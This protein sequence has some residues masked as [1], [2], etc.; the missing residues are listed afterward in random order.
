MDKKKIVLIPG[1]GF[2]DD[3]KKSLLMKQLL[4]RRHLDVEFFN[5]NHYFRMPRVAWKNWPIRQDLR[6]WLAEVIFDF[7]QVTVSIEDIK[8]PKADMYIGH[9][10]GS[11]LALKQ[12]RIPVCV[13]GSPAVLI[14]DVAKMQ[15]TLTRED[16]RS[17]SMI[18]NIVNKND[19]LAYPLNLPNCNDVI[20]KTYLS[21]VA[22]HTKY[23]QH[24]KTV[25]LITSWV[26]THLPAPKKQRVFGA[27]M[28]WLF[29]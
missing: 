15:G 2:H 19:P 12:D 5:W 28:Q 14:G 22:A 26:D 11:I 20:I 4:K 8:I 6:R 1:V 18:L 7:Q 3:G 21:P 24:R 16:M 13:F 27:G 9:S 25:N 29:R 17:N 23:W 10:A